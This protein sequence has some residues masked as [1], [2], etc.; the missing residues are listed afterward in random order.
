M[1]LVAVVKFKTMG[2]LMK[3]KNEPE[4][5]ENC[6]EFIED[7]SHDCGGHVEGSDEDENYSN[8]LGYGFGLLD[9]EG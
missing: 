2:K 3:N 7:L 9:M 1:G 6:G 4:Y 5:C 8:R